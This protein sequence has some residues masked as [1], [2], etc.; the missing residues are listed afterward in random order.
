[1]KKLFSIVLM[2]TFVLGLAGCTNEDLAAQLTEKEAQVTELETQLQNKTDELLNVEAELNVTENELT[3]AENDITVLEAQLQQLQEEL[4]ALQELYY[5]NIITF[6]VTD[7]FGVSRIKTAGIDEESEYDL[8]DLLFAT[9]PTMGYLSTD[10]GPFIKHLDHANTLNGN[11]LAFYKNNEMSMV[12]VKDQTFDDGDVFEFKVEWYDMT[13]KAVFDAIILFAENQAGNYIN[14]T[15]IDYNVLLGC[16]GFCQEYTEAQPYVNDYVAAMTLTTYADYFKATMLVKGNDT[17]YMGLNDIAETGDYGQTAYTL[18]GLDSNNHDQD[19]SVFVTAALEYFRNNT[20]Y[21]AGLD[22]GGIS[23]VALAKYKDE[24]GIQTLIDDY[25]NWIKQDQ[26]PS[27]GIMTR[28]MGWGSS[29]NASS[30]SMVILGL[31]ANGINPTGN[32]FT[33]TTDGISK[34]LIVRLI[35]FQ[36]ETGTFDWILNDDIPED[37]MF[38]TPQAFLALTTYFKYSQTFEAQNPYDF[39]QPV[40]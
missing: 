13:E 14:E 9:Y 17:L 21:D 4:E 28:D 15:F 8:F 24:T 19:Y 27:G 3:I 7:V 33:V 31:L 6:V 36:T 23:L 38:S 11:Y 12:G 34:N 37:A 40:N 16:H 1:M 30:I 26:L 20:P 2:L 22:T 18:L 25:V 35:E 29:E 5:D 10:Y 39:H 32:D